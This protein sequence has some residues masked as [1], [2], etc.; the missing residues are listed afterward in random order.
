MNT[1]LT[2]ACEFCGARALIEPRRATRGRLEIEGLGSA[3]VL[4]WLCNR[5]WT[6]TPRQEERPAATR[7]EAQAA[8]GQE[9]AARMERV[10]RGL[11]SAPGSDP[12]A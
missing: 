4:A 6:L 9:M 1:L 2:P 11:A 12:E 5:C 8:A 3:E 7:A 10:A